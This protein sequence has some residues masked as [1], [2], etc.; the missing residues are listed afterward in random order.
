MCECKCKDKITRE[1]P[2]DGSNV[3]VIIKTKY[4]LPTI[5]LGWYSREPLGKGWR[6]YI[7]HIGAR[8]DGVYYSTLDYM[9]IPDEMV[10]GW[11]ELSKEE[12]G[13]V[14]GK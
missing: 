6:L 9:S 1:P 3:K 7:P 11:L 2:S 10:L 4:Y 14:Y 8:A 13:L 5:C 12:I